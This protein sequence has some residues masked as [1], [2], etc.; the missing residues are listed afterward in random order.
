M[1]FQAV[2]YLLMTNY[3]YDAAMRRCKGKSKWM[4]Y[5]LASSYHFSKERDFMILSC[6][7]T[8]DPQKVDVY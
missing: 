6:G 2:T 1:I 5:Y 8:Q 3:D 4:Y 7:E